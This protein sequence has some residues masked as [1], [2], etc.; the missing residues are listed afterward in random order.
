MFRRVVTHVRRQPVAFVALFFALGG[1]AMATSNAIQVGTPAGGDVTGTYPNPSIAQNAVDSG[2]VSN[3]SLTDADINSANKD[4]AANTPSLRTLGS[5]GQQAMPGN[6]TPG[7]PPTG[8]A[9]GD[10][11]GSYPNPTIAAGA[12]GTGKFSSTIPAVRATG[13]SG[14]CDSNA[15]DFARFGGEDYDTAN[16]HSSSEPRYLIPPVAGV[17]RI[18]ASVAWDGNPNG[19]RLL[20]LTVNGGVGFGG[21]II[22]LVQRSDMPGLATPAFQSQ[23]ASTEVKLAAGDLVGAIINQNSGSSLGCYAQNFT[24]SWVAPG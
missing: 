1:G 20:A 10:L 7:G 18:S 15:V 21:Q 6:A 2:K 13:I 4:G 8:V 14:V 16:M 22:G 23:E 11:S 5:G 17:Y 19:D 3:G 9:S 12:V 24:M